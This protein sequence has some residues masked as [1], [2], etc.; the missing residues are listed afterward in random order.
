MM[1]SLTLCG[2]SVLAAS[3]QGGLWGLFVQS[4]DFFTVLLLLGSLIA[5]AII[6]RCLIDVRERKILPEASIGR[7]NDLMR[8]GR[9]EDLRAFVKHDESFPSRVLRQVIEPGRKRDRLGMRETAEIAA[10]EEVARWFRAI[11]PLNVVGNLGPLIGLAGTVWGMILAF[12]SLGA[13]GGQAGPA[14]LSMGISKALFHTLLGLTLAIPCLFVF[15][16]Y[17]SIVDRICTR[18][19]LVSSQ[20]IESLPAD[21]DDDGT[22]PPRVEAKPVSRMATAV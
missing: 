13:T 4:F 3:D 20:L 5:V 14:D 8:A 21:D 6:V 11:E 16:F 1:Q 22:F 18:G 19:M 7:I 10:S 15:G 17:R 12:T 9:E 2:A